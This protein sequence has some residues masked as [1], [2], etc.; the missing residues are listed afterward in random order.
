LIQLSIP[1]LR[2]PGAQELAA[3][4]R[5]AHRRTLEA[6]MQPLWETM[7]RKM[8]VLMRFNQQKWWF[9][10]MGFY[11]ILWDL[12]GHFTMKNGGLTMKNGEIW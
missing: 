6:A 2:Q 11:M 9:Y 10:I 12:Y 7:G 5:E 1:Q 8:V 3:D 4:R